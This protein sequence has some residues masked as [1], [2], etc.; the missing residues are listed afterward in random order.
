[1]DSRADCTVASLPESPGGT[2]NP[3]IPVVDYR[4]AQKNHLGWS[5]STRIT[6]GCASVPLLTCAGVGLGIGIGAAAASL[7]GGRIEPYKG[8]VGGIIIG[9]I[10]G[11]LSGI[12]V[13]C[14]LALDKG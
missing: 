6:V 10:V 4:L 8:V 13:L 11:V 7:S 9:S 14:Y 2:T 3:D 1:M 12:A 5:R